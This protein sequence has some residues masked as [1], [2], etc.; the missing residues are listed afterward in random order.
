MLQVPRRA[1]TPTRNISTGFF[2]RLMH[3]GSGVFHMYLG[4]WFYQAIWYLHFIQ[5]YL[6]SRLHCKKNIYSVNFT[7]HSLTLMLCNVFNYLYKLFML[8]CVFITFHLRHF[9]ID[10]ISRRWWRQFSIPVRLSTSLMSLLLSLFPMSITSH[11]RH[12]KETCW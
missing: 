4:I 2:P 5:I 12:Q 1:W 8:L 7:E 11:Y 9:S 10:N 3:F 6:R